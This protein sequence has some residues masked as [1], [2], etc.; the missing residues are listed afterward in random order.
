MREY[1][2]AESRVDKRRCR[3]IHPEPQEQGISSGS[4][5]LFPILPSYQ[6]TEEGLRWF[7]CGK[8]SRPDYRDQQR[9]SD[10]LAVAGV[11]CAAGGS[12]RAVLLIVGESLED[13]SQ[14]PADS[15][16]SYLQSIRVP[17][18]VWTTARQELITPWGK[19]DP[20]N[21]HRG[22]EEVAGK[23]HEHLQ[24]QRIVWLNGAFLPDE[25]ELSDQAEGISLPDH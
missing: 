12:R 19:A 15:I 21:C 13:H 17:L 24:R 1:P 9:L 23:L 22:F 4:L 6:L 11:R 14:Y 16:R 10:A 5:H 25:I 18:Y 3:Q 7:L 20:V 2:G 8:R